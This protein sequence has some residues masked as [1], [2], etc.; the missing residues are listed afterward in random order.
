MSNN[1]QEKEEIWYY[2]GNEKDGRIG[3][4]G[5][6]S[7]KYEEFFKEK[8]TLISQTTV[9][10]S[11]D[12]DEIKLDWEEK[13]FNFLKN[14]VSNFLGNF[15]YNNIILFLGSGASVNDK[16]YGKTMAQ[17][18]EEIKN[19]LEEGKRKISQKGDIDYKNIFSIEELREY[20]PSN[21]RDDFNLESVITQLELERKSKNTNEANL[22][23]I[24]NTLAYIK[25]K[26]FKEVNY[27]EI[28][29]N[30][31]SHGTIMNYLIKK[32]KD[33]GTKLNVVTTNYDA[34]VEKVASENGYIVFDGF[35]FDSAH[36]FDDDIFDWNLTKKVTG[37]NTKEQIYK[38]KVI[39]LLKLHGSIDWADTGTTV[40]KTSAQNMEEKLFSKISQTNKEKEEVDKSI[41]DDE[42]VMIFPS[43]NKYA[44]SYKEPYFDLL[45]RFQ[46][47]LH[48]PNTLLITAGF[49]FSDDHLSQMIFN[50]IKHNS[51][52]KCLVCDFKINPFVGKGSEQ[53]NSNQRELLNL[54][55][56]GY[57]ISYLKA[58]MNGEDTDLGFY[59]KGIDDNEEGKNK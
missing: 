8:K 29:T 45:H 52:F 39:N 46:D 5:E 58:A 54:F 34:V 15:P 30:D 56:K 28:N 44:Q 26:I 41:K 27:R 42:V 20:D 12:S 33:N 48:I 21:N 50:A 47:I 36:E 49:S 7:S 24:E 59:F 55:K 11:K 25:Y 18:V 1:E 53:S 37:V 9:D 2:Y 31:F 40:R 3:L 6:S 32:L 38:D 51:D 16:K 14:K 43:S 57:Q 10:S 17:L 19:D 13:F 22:E 35:G 4:K 23:K